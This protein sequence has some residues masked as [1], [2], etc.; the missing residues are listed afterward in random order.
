MKGET[1]EHP[2]DE[3]P[4]SVLSELYLMLAAVRGQVFERAKTA[5]LDGGEQWSGAFSWLGDCLSELDLSMQK[6]MERELAGVDD[7]IEE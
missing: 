1:V 6:A 3:V 2:L 5:I 7:G 4:H